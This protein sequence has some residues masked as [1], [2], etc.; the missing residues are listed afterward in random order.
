MRRGLP[1]L[2][3]CLA[4]VAL[5]FLVPADEADLPQPGAVLPETPSGFV[6][7]GEQAPRLEQRQAMASPM[8]EAA[9][10]P[11]LLVDADT[12]AA[13]EGAYIFA[14]RDGLQLARSDAEG[15]A[16]VRGVPL[17]ALVFSAAGYL[18]EHYFDRREEAAVLVR[19]MA[20]HGAVRVPLRA[21]RWAALRRF[22][23]VLPDG[24]AARDV[25]FELK[26]QEPQPEYLLRLAED[27]R[28][29]DF[30]AAFR[31]H[32][33]LSS[34]RH[35]DFNPEHW[36]FPRQRVR[37]G[38]RADQEAR[39]RFAAP[40]RF[41][42][43]ARSGEAF[44]EQEFE[45]DADPAEL[46]VQLRADRMLRGTVVAAGTGAPVVGAQAELWRGDELVTQ[47]PTAFDG[48]IALGPVQGAET[49]LRIQ[50]PAY[51]RLVRRGVRV[52]HDQRFELQAA[53]TFVVRGRILARA[54]GQPVA[55]AQL[56]LGD[57]DEPA[58][59]GVSDAEGRFELRS[60]LIEPMLRIE[61]EGYMEYRELLNAN[62][63][64][65][66]FQLLPAGAEAR[67]TAGLS[68]LIQVTVLDGSGQP[69]AK[70][71]LLL[72]PQQRP[73]T[74]TLPSRRILMGARVPATSRAQSDPQG[75]ARLEWPREEVL[76]LRAHDGSELQVAARLGEELQVTLRMK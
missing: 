29:P 27:L 15:R 47:Q 68:C 33:L 31:R 67:R 74:P 66:E 39:V 70:V 76:R 63:A 46:Q 28:E 69:A 72:E 58:A 54:G 22:R 55:G 60:A 35:P 30:A 36:F 14:A 34:L 13:I 42:I 4:A 3:L 56:S 11:Y 6:L 26:C 52:G 5:W 19:G 75:Q 9:A 23:F 44:A 48:S 51:R 12:G 21:D 20:R 43:R 65:R 18:A 64:A 71:P 10:V 8:P 49:E 40:G 25:E 61:A 45:V 37:G 16:E 73:A 2:I 50:H 24:S 32:E 38:L 17:D 62:G 57:L 7:H 59:T 53:E 1:L 41:R